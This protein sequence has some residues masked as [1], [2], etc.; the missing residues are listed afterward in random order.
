MSLYRQS[1]SPQA[2]VP[3]VVSDRC[4]L[5]SGCTNFQLATRSSAAAAAAAVP[6][7]AGCQTTCEGSPV[8]ATGTVHAVQVS[9]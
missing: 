5:Q 1:L 3:V 6:C 2:C 4:M 9:C 7:E 8:S